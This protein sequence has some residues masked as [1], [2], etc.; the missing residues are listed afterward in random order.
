MYQFISDGSIS[1]LY[2]RKIFNWDEGTYSKYTT[3]IMVVTS[4]S[5]CVLVPFLSYYLEVK[6]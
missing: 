5:S 6:I 2:T 3:V 4:I 1:Y